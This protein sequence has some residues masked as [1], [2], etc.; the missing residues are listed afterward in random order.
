MSRKTFETALK[1]VACALLVDCAVGF[2]ATSCVKSGSH[3]TSP[4]K[5][6]IPDCKEMIRVITPTGIFELECDHHQTAEIV[7]KPMP[8]AQHAQWVVKC[9]CPKAPVASPPL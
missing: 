4:S 9:S 3:Q 2:W 6:E 8:G 7:D 5:P 1:V